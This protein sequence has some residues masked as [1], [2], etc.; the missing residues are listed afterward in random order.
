MAERPIVLL[1]VHPTAPL[2]AAVAPGLA[3]VGVMLAAGSFNLNDEVT[4]VNMPLFSQYGPPA[5]QKSY[6]S[7]PPGA[8]WLC[9]GK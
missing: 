4:S 5:Y 1:Q 7:C 2:A 6:S 8:M 9:P 3:H